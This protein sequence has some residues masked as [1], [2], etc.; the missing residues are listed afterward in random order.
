MRSDGIES[1]KAEAE[2]EITCDCNGEWFYRGLRKDKLSVL[3]TLRCPL[4]FLTVI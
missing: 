4:S 3:P 2:G 1:Y